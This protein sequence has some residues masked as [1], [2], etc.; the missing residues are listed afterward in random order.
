LNNEPNL[1]GFKNLSG[2][3]EETT[4]KHVLKEEDHIVEQRTKPVR[5]GERN[6]VLKENEHNDS[7]YMD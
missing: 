6:H 4:F 5:F 2:L 7:K 1:S 3:E